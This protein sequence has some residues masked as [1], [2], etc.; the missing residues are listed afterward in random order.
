MFA[1]VLSNHKIGGNQSLAQT[2]NQTSGL[3][4]SVYPEM[5]AGTFSRTL[6]EHDRLTFQY[7]QIFFLWKISNN[8]QFSLQVSEGFFNFY[9]SFYKRI[10]SQSKPVS[11]YPLKWSMNNRHNRWL[12]SSPSED[13]CSALLWKI[14]I[15]IPWIIFK[16]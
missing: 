10:F 7:Y 8:F 6:S 11:R 5:C 1:K 9:F 2:V 14:T 3:M 15:N 13:G 12:A 16:L 4:G